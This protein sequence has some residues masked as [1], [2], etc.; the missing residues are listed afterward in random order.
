MLLE[1]M[2]VRGGT[3]THVLLMYGQVE[4]PVMSVEHMGEMLNGQGESDEREETV[5]ECNTCTQQQQTD[6]SIA[7]TQTSSDTSNVDTNNTRC[8]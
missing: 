7:D 6:V 8:R 3:T 1:H 4:R 2:M 5:N